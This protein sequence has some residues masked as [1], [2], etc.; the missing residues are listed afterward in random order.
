M[1]SKRKKKER[2]SVRKIDVIVAFVISL[3]HIHTRTPNILYSFLQILNGSRLLYSSMYRIVWDL[4]TFKRD[5]KIIDTPKVFMC[6]R[7]SDRQWT[8]TIY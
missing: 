6:D 1:Q 2:N 3:D 4:F 5:H 8:L 7:S